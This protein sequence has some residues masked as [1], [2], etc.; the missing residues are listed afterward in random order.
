MQTDRIH[1][2]KTAWQ[3]TCKRAGISDLHTHDLRREAGSRKLE[4]WPLHAVSK[5]LGHANVTMTL[6]ISASIR[7]SCTSSTAGS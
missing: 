6:R 1:D 7:I 2:I 5:W 4:E 3:N